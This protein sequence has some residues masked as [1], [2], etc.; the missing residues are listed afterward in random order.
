MYIASSGGCDKADYGEKYRGL[1]KRVKEHRADVK[2]HRTTSAFVNHV[3]QAGHLPKWED[4][5]TLEKNVSRQSRKV[6]EAMYIAINKNINQRT[7][8]LKWAKITAA[9]ASRERIRKGR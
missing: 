6:L 7:G 2:Y 1:E 8:D 9:V 4:A 3:D 5:I